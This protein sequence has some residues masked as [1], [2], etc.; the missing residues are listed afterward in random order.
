M[1]SFPPA[2]PDAN[3]TVRPG[4]GVK[5]GCVKGIDTHRQEEHHFFDSISRKQGKSLALI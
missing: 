4:L 5:T 2:L 3:W 1:A